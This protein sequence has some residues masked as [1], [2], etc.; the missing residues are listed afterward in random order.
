MSSS[1]QPRMDATTEETRPAHLAVNP[2]MGFQAM[3]PVLPPNLPIIEPEHADSLVKKYEEIGRFI[4]ETTERLREG[5]AAR[6]TPP[7]LHVE[8]V[9]EQIDGYL[10][11][12]LDSD[13]L[14]NVASP[15]AFDDAAEATWKE[16][17]KQ[18]IDSSIRPAF[19]SAAT[20]SPR[21]SPRRP[22]RW[23]ARDWRRSPTVR[24]PTAG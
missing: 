22:A 9:V 21:R 7:Q 2:A 3:L 18:A 10:A 19:S 20:S 5:V 24:S 4:R 23:T 16:R 8:M 14:L 11:G 13:P 15:E 1:S 17:L 12:S 6:R